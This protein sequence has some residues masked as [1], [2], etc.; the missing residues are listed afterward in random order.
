METYFIQSRQ[1]L[2]FLVNEDELRY[3]SLILVINRKSE[4]Q[5]GNVKKEEIDKIKQT[6]KGMLDIEDLPDTVDFKDNHIFYGSAKNK[7]T[8]QV[9]FKRAAARLTVAV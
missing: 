4:E 2:H 3:C 7:E 1:M 8:A 6:V 9:I 5:G